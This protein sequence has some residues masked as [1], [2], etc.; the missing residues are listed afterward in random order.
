MDK[1]TFFKMYR[2]LH[3]LSLSLDWKRE[4]RE[5]L[6]QPY[7]LKLLLIHI[8]GRIKPYKKRLKRKI[9]KLFTKNK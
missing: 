9:K 6:K 4:I 7:N 3:N 5:W 2:K 8:K 1:E